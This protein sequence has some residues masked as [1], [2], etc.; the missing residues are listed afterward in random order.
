MHY[1]KFWVV[2]IVLVC[3][4]FSLSFF[5]SSSIFGHKTL[6]GLASLLQSTEIETNLVSAVEKLISGKNEIIVE[7]TDSNVCYWIRPTHNEKNYLL[8]IKKYQS[9][10]GKCIGLVVDE[11]HIALEHGINILG[12][13][14]CLCSGKRYFLERVVEGQRVDLMVIKG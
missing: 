12:D 11:S 4:I 7:I 10:T 8:E 14:D 3:I 13:T 5:F 6:L 1:K 2:S 9:T